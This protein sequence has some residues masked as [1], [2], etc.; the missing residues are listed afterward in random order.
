MKKS[1]KNLT[2]IKERKHIFLILVCKDE[3]NFTIFYQSN[4]FKKQNRKE[5]N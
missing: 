1:K 3:F 2:E 5:I 4:I